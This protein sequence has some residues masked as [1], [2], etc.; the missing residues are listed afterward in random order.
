MTCLLS[1]KEV[2][3]RYGS[4]AALDDVDLCIHDGQRHALIGPN[5]AARPPCST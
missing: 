3:V 1:V 5:G 2:S 4:L